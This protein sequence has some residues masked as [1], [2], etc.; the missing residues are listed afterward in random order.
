MD[1]LAF[2]R[3]NALANFPTLQTDILLVTPPLLIDYVSI[4]YPVGRGVPS[5]HAGALGKLLDAGVA[6]EIGLS[7]NLICL[8][9]PPNAVH[10]LGPR[11][12]LLPQGLRL[13][14]HTDV[15]SPH[16][17]DV[18][19]VPR[20]ERRHEALQRIAGDDHDARDA[21]VILRHPPRVDVRRVEV[22]SYPLGGD[23]LLCLA[24]DPPPPVGGVARRPVR[25]GHAT[26]SQEERDGR[27]A[28]LSDVDESERPVFVR[29]RDA[30][31]SVDEPVDGRHVQPLMLIVICFVVVV[32][33]N[34]NRPFFAI[35][36][37]NPPRF[38]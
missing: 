17:V 7:V 37:D 3:D 29:Q 4:E 14:S 22:E 12:R 1:I 33:S 9:V 8:R 18:D 11:R 25:G 34:A 30:A 38:R 36:F 21:R 2:P 35:L 13:P 31:G 19:R 5:V 26:V 24:R 15:S 32:P 6:S 20:Q 27:P 10:G 16:L 28:G 23:G